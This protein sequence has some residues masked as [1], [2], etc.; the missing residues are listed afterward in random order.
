MNDADTRSRSPGRSAASDV[1][2]FI[3]FSPRRASGSPADALPFPAHVQWM[4]GTPLTTV[5][6]YPT[7]PIHVI[8]LAVEHAIDNCYRE[9][10]FDLVFNGRIL[11]DDS[12]AA[13]VGIRSGSMLLAVMKSIPWVLIAYE[14]GGAKIFD[15][16]S[17]SF[18]RSFALPG[19]A[20]NPK[21][22]RFRVQSGLSAVFSAD[23]SKVLMANALHDPKGISRMFDSRTGE[24][25]QDFPG[26]GA[27][28]AADSS[29]VFTV[30]NG[31]VLLHDTDS[32]ECLQTFDG[33]LGYVSSV[34][35]SADASIVA[36]TSYD[37]TARLFDVSTGKLLRTLAGHQ[38]SINMAKFS[39]DGSELLTASD[40]GTAKLWKTS[41]GELVRTFRDHGGRIASAMFSQ[42]ESR[43]LV[44]NVSQRSCALYCVISGVRVQSFPSEGQR[45]D[46]LVSEALLSKDGSRVLAAASDQ[47]AKLFDA[48]SGEVVHSFE[49]HMDAVT[50]VKFSADERTVLTA[51]DDG[52]AKLF[53]SHSGDVLRTFRVHSFQRGGLHSIQRRPAALQAS[54]AFI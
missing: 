5:V 16:E 21:F 44:V 42:D 8:R 10:R 28:L 48:E 54:F 45:N 41:S 53:D 12:E 52:T 43:V 22:H 3:P 25:L 24:L 30:V 11:A 18:V 32:G 13:A 26:G 50:T 46:F 40:D 19:S 37:A 51:S 38:A 9:Q 15:A 23:A 34:A 27:V 2:R 1:S 47:S 14:D 39:A 31:S 29:K 36:T 49:G 33:H 4:S 6:L 20:T 17:A 35:C 7:D